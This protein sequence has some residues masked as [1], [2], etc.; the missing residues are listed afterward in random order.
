M[1]HSN[2]VFRLVVGHSHRRMTVLVNIKLGVCPPAV[3]A[4]AVLMVIG[5]LLGLWP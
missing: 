2:Q 1:R 5:R 3:A 4:G